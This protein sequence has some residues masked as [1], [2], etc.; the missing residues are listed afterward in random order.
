M[1]LLQFFVLTEA[2][3]VSPMAAAKYIAYDDELFD[4]IGGYVY[5]Q[6][7]FREEGAAQLPR[8]LD[9]LRR[10]RPTHKRLYRGEPSYEHNDWQ[11]YKGHEMSMGFSSWSANVA[12]AKMHNEYTHDPM[13][14]YID[15]PVQMIALEDIVLWRNRLHPEENHYSGGQAEYFVLE[16]VTRNP[17]FELEQMGDSNYMSQM[18]YIRSNRR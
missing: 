6:D 3:M 15:E 1:K 4:A 2:N 16:P 5:Q 9:V 11:P 14:K 13:V 10:V 8:F 17:A 18:D 12:T 7:H